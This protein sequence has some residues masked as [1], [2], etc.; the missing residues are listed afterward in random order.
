MR[1][2][3]DHQVFSL[4]DV[5]GIS[6]YYFELARHLVRFDSCSVE[7][8]LGMQQNIF[9]FADPPRINTLAYSGKFVIP[10]GKSRY[11]LNELLS[12][13]WLP[14]RG[15]FDVYHPTHCRQLLSVR[16]RKMVV[17]HHDCAYEIYPR[18]FPS[19]ASVIA[20]RKQLFAKADAIICI[21]A[22]TRRDLHHF[23]DVPESKTS[24]VHHG[25]SQ[26]Q[27]ITNVPPAPLTD[28]PFLLY[29][30]SRFAYKNFDGLLRA[31]A[32]AQLDREFDLVVLGG[33]SPTAE[34]TALIRELR[35]NE[36]VHFLPA[37]SDALLAQT[38]SQAH[39][40]V[41]PS[42]Y[43][44]FGFPPLEAMSLNCPVLAAHTSSIPEVCQDAAF[45]F[46][47]Q[48]E[49]QFVLGLKRSCTDET[50]RKEKIEKGRQLARRY[51]WDRCA[52]E[53]LRIYRQ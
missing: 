43:E 41:Y 52:S 47:P 14:T 19:S 2:L 51:T 25:I 22:A 30:G 26:I 1:I 18:L 10:P 11:L 24:V 37:V 44:G 45:Y 13:L 6:R 21:S 29:V 23:Y 8:F 38:Y 35:I 20:M 5:G 3:Y 9:R 15:Q 12:D 17:T 4:Q 33:G 49:D 36:R 46:D 53:T 16:K 32:R 42:L 27:P 28:R 34:E 40:F 7:F 39:L 31:F 50:A 48:Q